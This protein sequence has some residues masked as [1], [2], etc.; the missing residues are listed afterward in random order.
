M[1]DRLSHIA[2]YCG[3][4][5]PGQPIFTQAAIELGNYLV[6]HQL[7]LVYGGSNCGIMKVLA[8]TVLN[9]RGRAIGIFTRDLPEK[10][11]RTDLSETIVADSLAERKTEMLRRADA[12]IAFPGSFG[13]WDEL[14]DALA[15]QKIQASEAALPVGVLNIDGYYDDL[16][17]F[18]RH[19]VNA[20]FTAPH[21]LARLNV[22]RTV[23]EL[24]RQLEEA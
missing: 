12:V 20:G 19:S 15:R 18:I 9:A 3:A 2:V 21:H 1:A 16:L 6:R 23:E 14:F 24:F 10:L 13:T 17:K 8:D 5:L 22:G 11:L 7:T 4:S